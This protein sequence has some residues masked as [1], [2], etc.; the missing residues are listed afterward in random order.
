MVATTAR[1][2]QERRAADGRPLVLVVDDEESYRQALATG[3]AREGFVVEL[4]AD[5][6]EALRRF[7]ASASSTPTWCCST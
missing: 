2:R 1:D 3:L 4:A 7:G 5:G 6:G